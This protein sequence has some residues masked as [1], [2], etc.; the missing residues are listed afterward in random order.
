MGKT[1]AEVFS[2]A[3]EGALST[4]EVLAMQILMDEREIRA[5]IAPKKIVHKKEIDV[6][7][8]ELTE[9][10]GVRNVRFYTVYP[11]ELF[12]AGDYEDLIEEAKKRGVAVNGFFVSIPIKVE[13]RIFTIFVNFPCFFTCSQER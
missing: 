13:T 7:Q 4:A 8:K 2:L 3:S 12:S 1:V 10:L 6:L 11:S 5:K 9:K